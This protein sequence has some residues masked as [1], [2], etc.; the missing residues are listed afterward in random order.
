MGMRT[1]FL[2]RS[3]VF[4]YMGK[5]RIVVCVYLFGYRVTQKQEFVYSVTQSLCNS[6]LGDVVLDSFNMVNG[7][8]DS[9]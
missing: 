9:I 7:D 1:H 5:L 6:L 3:I 2:G 4:A 8:E